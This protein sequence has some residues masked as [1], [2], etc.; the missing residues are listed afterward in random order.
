[1]ELINLANYLWHR[2]QA[3]KPRGIAAWAGLESL[4]PLRRTLI[5]NKFDGLGCTGSDIGVVVFNPSRLLP[6]GVSMVANNVTWEP[7]QDLHSLERSA[8]VDVDPRRFATSAARQISLSIKALSELRASIAASTARND[9]SF[10]EYECA[11]LE[12]LLSEIPRQQGCLR[13]YC[14]RHHI[15]T[16]GPAIASALAGAPR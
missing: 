15:A 11:E 7:E 5:H 13:L 9:T 12:D 3:D 10:A 2:G 4:G 1:V 6:E 14:A 8:L 16:D